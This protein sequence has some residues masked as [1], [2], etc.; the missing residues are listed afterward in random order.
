MA[1]DPILIA[2]LS[3]TRHE[4]LEGAASAETDVE[5]ELYQTIARDAAIRLAVARGCRVP[6]HLRTSTVFTRTVLT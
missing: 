3:R 6:A 1:S 4:A 5:R 2:E